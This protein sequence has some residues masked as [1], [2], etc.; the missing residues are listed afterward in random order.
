MTT[1]P[2]DPFYSGDD[3][4]IVEPTSLN[5]DVSTLPI[6]RC[7]YRGQFDLPCA[8]SQT[9]LKLFAHVQAQSLHIIHAM[10]A[11]PKEPQPPAVVVGDKKITSLPEPK[12]CT[13]KLT[14]SER[15]Q[16]EVFLEDIISQT[17]LEIDRSH[18]AH[19]GMCEMRPE[20]PLKTLPGCG[21]NISIGYN[22]ID[23][24]A[25]AFA[26]GNIMAQQYW[27]FQC[28][29]SLVHEFG[30]ALE[31][32]IRGG[33]WRRRFWLGDG[34]TSEMDYELENRIFGG[35]L[36]TIHAGDGSNLGHECCTSGPKG[37]QLDAMV[38][39]VEW[40]STC[41]I[42]D[43][44]HMQT[45]LEYPTQGPEPPK[46]FHEWKVPFEYVNQMFQDSFWGEHLSENGRALH[47]PRHTAF[48]KVMGNYTAA[49]LLTPGDPRAEVLVLDGYRLDSNGMIKLIKESPWREY[50]R[51][52]DWQR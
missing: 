3:V 29:T 36:T 19:Y 47:P 18:M 33:D 42:G 43:Y 14:A 52:V 1:V 9:I 12:S 38:L 5:A 50:D 40:P 2:R 10:L 34:H 46:L 7:F 21:S 17:K 6:Y 4:D 32:A 30:H 26:S 44:D 27:I 23:A 51:Q 22:A 35:I 39:S 25:Q 37:L 16:V 28:V 41:K 11:E 15:E 49:R 20:R 24:I 45:G 13:A 8:G 31:N 48:L